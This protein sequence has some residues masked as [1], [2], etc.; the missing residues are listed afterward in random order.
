MSDAPVRRR[1]KIRGKVQG[2][3][4]R[5]STKREAHR[6]G[7]LAGFVRNRVDGSVEVVVQGAPTPVAKLEAWCQHGPDKAI[8][9]SVEASTE[10]V[11]EDE[12]PFRVE[13]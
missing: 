1:L 3:W 12:R 6:I 7:G 11:L 13:R 9:D 4:F 10:P 5:E 8:V 2:V